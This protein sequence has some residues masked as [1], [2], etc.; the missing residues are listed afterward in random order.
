M[1]EIALVGAGAF[2]AFCL[3]AF[4]EMPE[5]SIAAVVDTDFERAQRFASHYHAKAY[6]SLEAMLEDQAV[7]IVALNTPPFLHASQGLAVL[8]AG[9]HL[10][11]E[12]PLALKVEEGEALV[13]AAEQNKVL[14]TVDYVMRQNPV[15]GAAA[16]LAHHGILGKLRH[17][18]LINHAAGL[19]LPDNHWFWRKSQS[20]GIWVEHGIH[21]FD[22]FAWVAGEPGEIIAATEYKRENGDIDRVEALAHY[23]NVAAHFYHGFDQSSMTEQTTVK[24]TFQQGYITLR[25]WVPTTLELL[26][27]ITPDQLLKFLPG[28]VQT[29]TQPDGRFLMKAHLVEGKSSVYRQCIQNG[30]R[31]FAYAIKEGKPLKVTGKHGLESLRMAVIAENLG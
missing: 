17:M 7:T 2:G 6:A 12:K 16:A 23:G 26:T 24:L 13:R 8:N 15:W 9:K 10:F 25:E 31:Q 29:F 4:N 22:A 18:D 11:C 30:M 28:Q 14:L 19:N 5:V 3:A 20:G 27:T 1:T 21:F